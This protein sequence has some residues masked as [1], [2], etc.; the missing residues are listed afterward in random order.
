MSIAQQSTISNSDFTEMG[1]CFEVN[2]DAQLVQEVEGQ[3]GGLVMVLDANVDHYLS[4][5]ESEGFY[6]T[7]R[8]PNETI[9]NKGFGFTVSPGEEILI[10]I[11]KLEVE[12]LGTP[13][14]NCKDE[15]DIFNSDDGE[16]GDLLTHRECFLLHKLWLYF[17]DDVCQCYPWYFYERYLSQGK[18]RYDSKISE[19]LEHYLMHTLDNNTRLTFNKT[20]KIRANSALNVYSG[21]ILKTIDNVANFS[22]LFYIM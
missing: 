11:E 21:E 4:N 6:I 17:S 1:Y 2:D 12:R 10:D 8:M 13:W 22:L 5:V 7:L 20:C 3:E 19:R 18:V 9:V 16:K 15:T 14:G